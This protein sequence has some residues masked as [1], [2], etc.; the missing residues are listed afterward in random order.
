MNHYLPSGSHHVLGLTT[1]ISANE[2][3]EQTNTQREQN[4]EK[5][6]TLNS[7]LV[8]AAQTKANNMVQLNYWSHD[9]PSGQ[10][11]WT[12]ISA[13][14]YKYQSAGENLAYGFST[15][16]NLMSAWMHSPEHRANILDASYTQVGFGIV[17]A[18]S[19]Q[20]QDPETLVD[21][22]YADPAS[23][24]V[25][26]VSPTNSTSLPATSN[27]NRL[28]LLTGTN[29]MWL[30]LTIVAGASSLL[31]YLTVKHVLKWR[32][33]VAYSEQF[34]VDHPLFDISIMVFVMFAYVAMR[35]VGYIG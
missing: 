30:E 26:A 11:P 29:A 6:L 13:A 5:P 20:G 12:F 2:L 21:A 16:E 24:A 27:V 23:A 1:D 28:Q 8:Q 33:V 22:M 7:E 4:G 31:T 10:T 9:T 19:Y 18:T 35:S 32:R 14:G 17:N 15:T 34:V 3:L 25:V